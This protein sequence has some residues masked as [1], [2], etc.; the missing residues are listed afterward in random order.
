MLAAPDVSVSA[1]G[2]MPAPTLSSLAVAGRIGDPLGNIH[3][4]G[5]LI[6]G[7]GGR[8]AIVVGGRRLDGG[9]R[10]HVYRE[11][12]RIGQAGLVFDV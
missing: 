5:L 11:G 2:G 8:H 12:G 7:G 1:G 4:H 9:I 3:I 6:D 10:I